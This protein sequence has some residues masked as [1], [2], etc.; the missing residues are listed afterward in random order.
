MKKY[1]L[2]L[3]LLIGC[4]TPTNT[5]KIELTRPDGSIQKTYTIH[6]NTRPIV[7]QEWGGQTYIYNQYDKIYE[8]R[9]D[10]PTGW[11]LNIE[12]IKSGT[13]Q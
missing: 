1:L 9:I 3:V 13:K 5:Y 6:R 7:Y 8:P 10:A 11:Y 12:L 2:L 4:S